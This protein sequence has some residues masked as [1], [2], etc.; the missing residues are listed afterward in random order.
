MAGRAVW[1]HYVGGMTQSAVARHFGIPVSRAH[2]MISRAAK[3]GAVRVFVDAGVGECV[4]LE[5]ELTR[6]YGLSRC[7]VA[8]DLGEA[9]RAPFRALGAA[10]ASLLMSEMARG[11]VIGIGH[12]AT[13]SAVAEALPRLEN[14]TA[15]FVS[16]LGGLTRRFAANPFDVMHRLA[17]K[18]GAE[19]Y[20]LPAPLF[21]NSAADREVLWAQRGVS[22]IGALIGEARVCFVGVGA[23]DRVG[24]IAVLELYDE[25]GGGPEALRAKGACAEILGQ[26]LDAEGRP[27]NTRYDDRVMAPALDALR[28]REVIAVAGGAG[29]A[30]ALDTALKSGI[31]TGLVTDENTAR[32]M[33]GRGRERAGDDASETAPQGGGQNQ[34]RE[35]PSCMTR[36]KTS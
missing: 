16:L 20:L 24:S 27:V 35:E 2:R 25:E 10:G 7:V 21:A 32:A 3:N 22:E 31:V 13:L 36:K 15:R 6:R 19:A 34:S 33:L 23:V 4:A 29:K 30:A 8:P 5:N 14:K 1:M 12:G 9:G 11:G 26:F 17:E 18:T 28:G